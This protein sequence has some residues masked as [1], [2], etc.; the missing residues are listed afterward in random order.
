MERGENHLKVGVL[1]FKGF[2]FTGGEISVVSP[3]NYLFQGFS[4][5]L[6]KRMMNVSVLMLL[7]WYYLFI[8]RIRCDHVRMSKAEYALDTR[9]IICKSAR[10]LTGVVLPVLAILN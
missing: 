8:N 4:Y 1:R 6:P 5:Y 7:R 3:I 2:N 9:Q 10:Q